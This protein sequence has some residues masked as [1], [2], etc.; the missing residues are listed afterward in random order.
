M[1]IAI[2]SGT[3]YSSAAMFDATWCAAA[4]RVPWRAISSAIS[5]NEVTS[6]MIER[7]A[8][9]PSRANCPMVGQ[10]GGSMARQI[11]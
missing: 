1:A 3:M 7:P 8:G 5:V 2:D 11:A 4:D 10:C 9:I 6:T